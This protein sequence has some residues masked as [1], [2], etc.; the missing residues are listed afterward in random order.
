MIEPKDVA[1]QFKWDINKVTLF[2]A[3]ALED[4]NDHNIAAALRVLNSG[5][6]D[7]ACEFIKLEME[8]QAAG[9]MTDEL[10]AAQRALV[11]LAGDALK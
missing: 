6:Y 1:A 2:C 11:H 4:A 3:D 9:E 7:L 8:H 5:Q 10:R